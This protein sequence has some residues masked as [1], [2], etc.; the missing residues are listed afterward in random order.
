M[1]NRIARGFARPHVVLA[2]IGVALIAAPM[3]VAVG[4]G[5]PLDGGTRNPSSDASQAYTAETEII[6]D[7][8]TYGTRQSNKRDGDGGGAIYGCRSNPGAEPCIRSNNLKG[9]RAFEFVT[10]GTEAGRIE[11]GQASGAPLTT[12]ATG[13]A[14]GFNADKVDGKDASDLDD[15]ETLKGK[16]AIDLDDAE[17]L[18]GNTVSDLDDA[19]TLDGKPATDFAEASQ[20]KFAVVDGAGN[21]T[22][23]RERGGA[24]S[25]TFN[26]AA[27]VYRVVFS[28]DVS[29]CSYTASPQRDTADQ[30]ISVRGGGESN[31]VRVAVA[32]R[33]DF[34]LQVIC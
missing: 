34:Q 11:V 3:A 26:E 32:E 1:F 16:T 13:V 21:G 22:I 24:T 19:E 33:T 23:T 15:A 20:L 12:N 29:A 9:G 4:E 10:A 18:K 27:L 14:T 17:T 31:V 2:T 8:G 30:T 28:T 5:Q 25:V 6:S 7:T